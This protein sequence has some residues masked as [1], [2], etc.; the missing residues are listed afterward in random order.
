MPTSRC[1]GVARSQVA[2]ASPGARGRARRRGVMA[3][4]DSARN[5]EIVRCYRAGETLAQVGA[6]FDLSAE[7][8][9]QLLQRLGEPTRTSGEARRGKLRAAPEHQAEILRR[10]ERDETVTAIATAVGVS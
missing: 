2:R 5:A 3:A 6:R 4:W 8:V 1:R 7:G 9:R 10:R